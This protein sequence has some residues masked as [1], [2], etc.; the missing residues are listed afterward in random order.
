MSQRRGGAFFMGTAF[1]GATYG[2]W[3]A[4]AQP[5]VPE[6][7]GPFLRR[8]PLTIRWMGQEQSSP[9]VGSHPLTSET[10]K[11]PV[12]QGASSILTPTNIGIVAGIVALTAAIVV[13]S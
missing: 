10:A 8:R 12:K 2:P 9:P 1:F 5:A 3:Y 6:F 13:L 11:E 7:R 4:V